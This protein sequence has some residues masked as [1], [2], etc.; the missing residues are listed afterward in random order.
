[1]IHVITIVITMTTKAKLVKIGNS[2]GIRISKSELKRLGVDIGDELEI[3]IRTKNSSDLDQEYQ[4][5]KEK[6]G[7]TLANLAH[8]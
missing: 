2:Q 8:R 3:E 6:Y 4:Q 7:Q 1:M 5:F